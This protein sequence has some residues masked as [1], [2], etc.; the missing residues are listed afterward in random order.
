[1][2]SD[3][4]TSVCFF[5]DIVGENAF[6]SSFSSLLRSIYRDTNKRLIPPE[7]S[8]HLRHGGSWSHCFPQTAADSMVFTVLRSLCQKS[9]AGRRRLR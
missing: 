6:S 3:R 4:K 1:M 8:M 5:E 9:W 7:N 2:V